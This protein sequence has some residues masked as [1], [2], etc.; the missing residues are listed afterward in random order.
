MHFHSPIVN[1][2][3]VKKPS[4]PGIPSSCEWAKDSLENLIG[5]IH[6]SQPSQTGRVSV[7][8]MKPPNIIIGIV[9]SGAIVVAVVTS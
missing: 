4:S 1:P 8:E 9:N 5:E 2:S 3:S 6:C 7:L